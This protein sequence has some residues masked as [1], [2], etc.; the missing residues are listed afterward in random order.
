MIIKKRLRC[1]RRV[2]ARRGSQECFARKHQFKNP[3]GNVFEFICIIPYP[4]KIP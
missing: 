3:F 2:H 1:P 4:E